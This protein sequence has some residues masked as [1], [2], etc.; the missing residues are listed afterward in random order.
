MA[1][2]R[3]IKDT[4]A[5]DLR[6]CKKLKKYL[7]CLSF[8]FVNGKEVPEIKMVEVTACVVPPFY[9]ADAVHKA[10]KS[11]VEKVGNYKAHSSYLSATLADKTEAMERLIEKEKTRAQ[12]Y[13]EALL[14]V[15]DRLGIEADEA[16]PPKELA[17]QIVDT[18][19]ETEERFRYGE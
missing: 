4:P 11:M 10:I 13:Q 19:W 9:K 7:P 3:S 16:T 17:E 12:A 6:V 15:A 18:V 1:R 8:N 2:S 14:Y 5:E